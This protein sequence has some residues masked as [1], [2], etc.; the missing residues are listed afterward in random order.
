M[1]ITLGEKVKAGDKGAG[2]PVPSRIRAQSVNWWRGAQYSEKTLTKN[3][4]KLV[5]MRVQRLRN[6][7]EISR[8]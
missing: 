3:A 5:R 7:R 1:S 4:P 6:P 2:E 8:V